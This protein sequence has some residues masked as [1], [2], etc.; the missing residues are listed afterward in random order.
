MNA[1]LA[2][3]RVVVDGILF[4]HPTCDKTYWNRRHDLSDITMNWTECEKEVA[5]ILEAA[6]EA[7]YDPYETDGLD[8]PAFIA[9]VESEIASFINEHF[10][11]KPDKT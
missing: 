11:L 4:Y 3:A 10:G 2:S 7:H 1:S 6:I 5:K 9:Q 8:R